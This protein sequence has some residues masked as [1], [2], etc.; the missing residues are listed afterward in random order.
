MAI[1]LCRFSLTI[2]KENQEILTLT[3]E[4]CGSNP[5]HLMMTAYDN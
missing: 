4:E 1:I 3:Y 2:Y 5:F